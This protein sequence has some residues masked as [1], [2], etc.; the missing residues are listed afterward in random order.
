MLRRDWSDRRV[1]RVQKSDSRNSYI[2]FASW[3]DDYACA[4]VLN[5]WPSIHWGGRCPNKSCV[6]ETDH[7]A[8]DD[9]IGR[10]FV[11]VPMVPIQ[12]LEI[13][14]CILLLW[15]VQVK[16]TNS[17]SEIVIRIENYLGPELLI[18]WHTIISEA[19]TNMNQSSLPIQVVQE[20]SIAENLTWQN[21]SIAKLQE[22]V[23]FLT[24]A[25]GTQENFNTAVVHRLDVLQDNSVSQNTMLQ[26]IL[27]IVESQQ[28]HSRKRQRG[29]DNNPQPA[30]LVQTQ[31]ITQPVVVPEYAAQQPD[32]PIPPI[33]VEVN[34][35]VVVQRKLKDRL[36]NI[37]TLFY[38]WYIE[39]L[40]TYR[41]SDSDERSYVK[42]TV[43][44]LILY[45]KR[46]LPANCT[47]LLEKPPENLVERRREW[48]NELRLLSLSAKELTMSFI[49]NY[50]RTVKNT[51]LRN[52]VKDKAL[53]FATRKYLM[54]I[55]LDKFPP[56]LLAD[57]IT[58]S[59][60]Y[61]FHNVDLPHFHK[62]I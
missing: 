53:T 57:N 61:V 56:L 9:F 27:D 35:P 39:E 17:S 6:P 10:I 48:V 22:E 32:Q 23:H 15:H 8:F 34:A 28:Q 37:E 46:F 47:T 42:N 51:P 54:S 21:S 7:R 44:T 1:G 25:Q 38:T 60:A 24:N 52:C 40:W 43:S 4:L 45:M 26:R 31:I 12:I 58:Q 16:E 36:N 55:P 19:Y 20:L 29:G 14:G 11:Y 13:W 2:S 59:T 5:S 30:V 18:R 49:D 50:Y 41:G 33:I 62:C 3:Q